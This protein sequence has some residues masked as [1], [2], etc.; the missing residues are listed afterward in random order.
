MLYGILFCCW[1]FL[2]LFT[3]SFVQGSSLPFSSLLF[4]WGSSPF[5]SA[6]HQTL[7]SKDQP[8]TLAHWAWPR[9]PSSLSRPASS[10][11]SAWP[12]SPAQASWPVIP[13]HPAQHS[14]SNSPSPALFACLLSSSWLS[15]TLI[16]FR[17]FFD[18]S[19]D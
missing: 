16:S 8:A 2:F 4:S 15:W 6:C 13:I 19:D 18:L 12:A 17:T 9:S 3:L 1:S 5:C 11:C 7:P 10:A 14:S